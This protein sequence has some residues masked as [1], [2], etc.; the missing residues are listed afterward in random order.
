MQDH[1]DTGWPPI[2][3]AHLVGPDV[4][5]TGLSADSRR[6]EPGMLFAA[7]PGTRV[8]GRHYIPDALRHGAIAVLAET[9][10]ALPAT[11]KVI[12]LVTDDC[13]PR[14]FARMASAYCGPQPACIAAVTGTN[15]KTSVATFASQIWR[16]AGRPAASLGTLGIESD[17]ASQA[18]LDSR[19]TTPDVMDLHHALARLA[20]D[21][22]AHLALEASSHGL[23][24]H[25]LDGVRVSIAAFTNLSHDHLDYHGD[26]AAYRRAKERLFS[27]IV[28]TGGSVVLNRDSGEY[29]TLRNIARAR[30]LSVLDYG[31]THGGVRCDHM[32]ATPE[33]WR[34]TLTIGGTTGDVRLPLWGRFQI[35]NALAAAGI[36][37]A[38]GLSSMQVLNALNRLHGA[39]GRMEIIGATE[40]GGLVVVDYA[41]TPDAL[42]A[43]LQAM[44]PHVTGRLVVVFGCG[45]DR[46]GAKRPVMGRI[47]AHNADR[48]IVTDDNPRTENAEAIR[49]QILA[50]APDALHIA[51]RRQAI[52]TA[53]RGLAAGDGLLIAGKGHETGQIIGDQILPFDDR[54]VAR[55]LIGSGQGA[56]HG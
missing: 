9:G 14:R 41:H 47:A 49:R 11:D 36:G 35:L 13:V 40:A 1:T 37:L 34:L 50:Q 43:A 26:M 23:A 25:R 32:A 15:G 53:V 46:D 2:P 17:G 55:G 27:E 19:L 3:A 54:A 24:Q 42:Q 22:V 45:G 33:G 31:L 7:L 51:D 21:G 10:T 52:E 38:S 29:D 4:D 44:R 5:I 6:I 28:V 39:P 48:V 18:R 56:A 12:S 8:D 30:N 20:G 16:S